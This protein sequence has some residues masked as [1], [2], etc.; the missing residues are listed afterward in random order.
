M[1]DRDEGEEMKEEKECWLGP[2]QTRGYGSTSLNFCPE[3]GSAMQP[4]MQK[5]WGQLKIKDPYSL[6]CQERRLDKAKGI[7]AGVAVSEYF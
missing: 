7:P 1:Y 6:V 2:L 4:E 3:M 5:L